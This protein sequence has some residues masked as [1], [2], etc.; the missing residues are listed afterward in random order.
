ME[1]WHYFRPSEKDWLAPTIVRILALGVL[2][3]L[4]GT[5]IAPFIYTV[6]GDREMSAPPNRGSVS[7][8][9]VPP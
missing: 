1:F 4:G 6:F 3:F 8:P 7:D 5:G 9:F 2:V